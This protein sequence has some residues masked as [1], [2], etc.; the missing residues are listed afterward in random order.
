[1]ADIDDIINFM[2]KITLN[3]RED[4]LGQLRVELREAMGPSFYDEQIDELAILAYEDA[5]KR[6]VKAIRNISSKSSQ[7]YIRSRL[8][9]VR[10]AA[11]RGRNR[12]AVEDIDSLISGLSGMG[13]GF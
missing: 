1:M 13:L 2:N 8:R 9:D 12:A 6:D 10:Q 4:L 7:N 11:S 5:I 3:A